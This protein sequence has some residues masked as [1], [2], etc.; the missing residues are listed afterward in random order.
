MKIIKSV[1]LVSIVLILSMQI[2][3]WIRTSIIEQIGGVAWRGIRFIGFLILW[4]AVDTLFDVI[5]NRFSKRK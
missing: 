2:E 5:F 1:V 4:G 3:D